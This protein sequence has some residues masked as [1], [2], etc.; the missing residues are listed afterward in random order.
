MIAHVYTHSVGQLPLYAIKG[1]SS[2]ARV[3]MLKHQTVE[4]NANVNIGNKYVIKRGNVRINVTLRRVRAT[5]V[6]VEK[7]INNTYC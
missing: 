6:A 7:A 4:L 2:E 3:F 1:V 5:I